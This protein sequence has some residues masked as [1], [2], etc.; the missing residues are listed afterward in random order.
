[1]KEATFAV[2]ESIKIM[3]LK[4]MKYADGLWLK[5]ASDQQEQD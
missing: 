5:L 2:D 1:M 4:G 3:I